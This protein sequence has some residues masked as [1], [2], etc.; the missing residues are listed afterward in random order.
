[1]SNNVDYVKLVKQARLGN[2]ESIEQLTTAAQ[3]RLRVDVYRLTL[4]HDLTQDIVQESILEMLKMLNELKE[5]DKFWPWLYKI[6]LNKLR[7]HKR[8]EKVRKTVPISAVGDADRLKDSEQA[9]SNMVTEELKETVLKAM[10]KLRPQH[11][12]VL[13]MRCY[14]EMEYSLI[15][16][17]LGCSEFAAKMLFYRAKKALEKELNSQGL[18]RGSLL[19][20]LILFGKMTAPSEAAAAK[21]SVTATAAK[22]GVTAG[23]AGLAGS[24]TGIVCLAT[25]GLLGAGTLAATSALDKIKG[26]SDQKPAESY[27]AAGL[28]E[29]ADKGVE[30][31]W[32]Y[33]PESADGPVM[34]RVMQPDSRRQQLYCAWRQNEQANYRFDKRRNTVYIENY[35]MWRPDLSVMRLPTD[36]PVLSRFLAQVEGRRHEM[37]YVPAKGEGILVIARQSDKEN[38]NHSDVMRHHYMLEAECFLYDW[39]GGVRTIDRRDA[40]HKRGWTYFRITGHIEGQRVSGEG[41]LPFVYAAVEEHG[42]WLR[43]RIGDYREIVDSGDAAVVYDNRKVVES[44]EARAFF[45]GF[46]R[47]WMGLHSV[48]TV[49]RYAAE[50]GVRFETKYNKREEKAEITLRPEHAEI[51]YTVDMKGDVV[52]KIVFTTGDDKKGELG[53]SYL[54]DVSEAGGEFIEPRTRRSYADRRGEGPG[55]LWLLRLASLP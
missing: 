8:A 55:I 1:M 45:K 41:R 18:G 15:A 31:C 11:R 39:P 34:M 36:G 2:R 5:A 21:V 44:Y 12:A 17:S 26:V 35:R 29:T 7:L 33:F 47:P 52:E 37:E 16:E 50:Q 6:A 51:V 48:D 23:L 28:P 43:L 9:M 13:T 54:Q 19:M 25:A 14:R 30:E 53:F 4:E 40:M 46:S 42:P 27:Q 38:G 24:K 32:Y 20:A 49:R 10:R 3:E 22:V